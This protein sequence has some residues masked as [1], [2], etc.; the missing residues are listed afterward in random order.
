[1]FQNLLTGQRY[2]GGGKPFNP[3]YG[4]YSVSKPSNRSKV[5]GGVY[6]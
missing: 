2:L 1:M 5:F 3:F 6:L 4:E